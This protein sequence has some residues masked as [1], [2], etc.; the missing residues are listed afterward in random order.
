MYAIF[1]CC[2]ARREVSAALAVTKRLA[3]AARRIENLNRKSVIAQVVYDKYKMDKLNVEGTFPF[4]ETWI[5]CNAPMIDAAYQMFVRPIEIGQQHA[6]RGKVAQIV[7]I[8]TVFAT[9]PTDLNVLEE[10]L[11][12]DDDGGVGEMPEIEF[13]FEY[14]SDVDLI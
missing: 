7:Q 1:T 6:I 11:D 5:L 12:V 10:V 13:S 8:R 2:L 9:D 14:D 4:D 3:V